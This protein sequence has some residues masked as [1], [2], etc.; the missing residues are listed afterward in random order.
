MRL[1]QLQQSKT[2]ILFITPLII[3]IVGVLIYPFCNSIYLSFTN[4]MFTYEKYYLIGLENYGKL[5]RDDL[6]WL[7]LKHSLQFTFFGVLGALILGLILAL[8]LNKDT[9]YIGFFRGG[10]YFCPGHCHLLSSF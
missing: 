10:C 3:C 5:F 1:K 9:K 7:A 4:K 2:G 8:L 6:F